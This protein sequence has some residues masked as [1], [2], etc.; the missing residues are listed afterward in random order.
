MGVHDVSQRWVCGK[1]LIA[2]LLLVTVSAENT[3][4]QSN[5]TEGVDTNAKVF[6]HHTWPVRQLTNTLHVD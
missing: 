4:S 3:N 2:V 1:V 6:Y 5:H